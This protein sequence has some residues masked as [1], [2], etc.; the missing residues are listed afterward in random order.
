MYVF[1]FEVWLFAVKSIRDTQC[2]FKL[3]PSALGKIIFATLQTPGWAHDVE[4]LKR[5]EKK[6]IGIIEMPIHWEAVEGSK[7]NLLKDSFKM[8]V[9]VCKISMMKMDT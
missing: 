4:I 3:Y 7:I 5:A 8:F 9:E 1:H 6:G 2:G